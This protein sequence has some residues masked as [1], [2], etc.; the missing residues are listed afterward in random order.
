MQV[1]PSLCL[2]PGLSYLWSAYL[3]PA[4]PF[5]PRDPLFPSWSPGHCQLFAAL[6]RADLADL[7]RAKPTKLSREDGLVAGSRPSVPPRDIVT[8]HVLVLTFHLVNLDA[9]EVEERT[10]HLGPVHLAQCSVAT[11][12]E[13]LLQH[14]V[15]THHILIRNPRPNFAVHFCSFLSCRISPIILSEV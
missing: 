15:S 10:V 9:R 8:A 4:L 3:G 7:L 14:F 13:I 2:S 11:D 12:G 1:H 5:S 6:L